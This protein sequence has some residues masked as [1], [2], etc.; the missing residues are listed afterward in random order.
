MNERVQAFSDHVLLLFGR[1][2]GKCGRG[3]LLIGCRLSLGRRLL[4]ASRTTLWRRRSTSIACLLVEFDGRLTCHSGSTAHSTTSSRRSTSATSTSSG[5]TS[6]TARL[7]GHHAIAWHGIGTWSS[8]LAL[9]DVTTPSAHHLRAHGVGRLHTS[10]SRTPRHVHAW[11]TGPL[12]HWATHWASHHSLAGSISTALV[13][14]SLQLCP[15]DITTLCQGNKDGLTSNKLSIHLIHSTSSILRSRVANESKP[16]RHTR[17]EILHDTS[18]GNCSHGREL[19]TQDIIGDRVF[20]VLNVEI[21]TLEFG[22]TLHLLRLVFLTKLTLTFS[23]LLSTTNKQ[24]LGGSFSIFGGLELFLIQ[25]IHSL[26]GGLM[27]HK[28]DESKSK[29]LWLV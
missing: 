23:L 25:F 1:S 27:F 13:V 7:G 20:Q 15:T 12:G 16:T 14:L 10:R 29:R 28:V 17:L 21:H 6:T 5:S 3:E 2:A 22:N 26:G 18:T 19:I 24:D 9:H 11:S 4:H 8:G